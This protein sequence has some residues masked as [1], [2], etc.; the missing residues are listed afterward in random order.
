MHTVRVK[1]DN[2][3]PLSCFRLWASRLL[4]RASHCTSALVRGARPSSSTSITAPGRVVLAVVSRVLV[5]VVLPVTFPLFL[6]LLGEGRLQE[7]WA[8]EKFHRLLAVGRHPSRRIF[9]DTGVMHH[10]SDEAVPDSN[11]VSRCN[12]NAMA[13]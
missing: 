13:M 8:A 10:A 12:G 2:H 3:Q 7:Q 1:G 9:E 11:S 6:S 4:L 5:F